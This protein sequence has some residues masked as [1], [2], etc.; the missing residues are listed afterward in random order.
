MSS[1]LRP[2]TTSFV[3]PMTPLRLARM[4][5]V[6]AEDAAARVEAAIARAVLSARPTNLQEQ[7]FS[8]IQERLSIVRDK[9]DRLER[10]G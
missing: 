4:S 7:L 10:E 6:E 8:L 5:V 2:L 1:C 9:V 3:Q